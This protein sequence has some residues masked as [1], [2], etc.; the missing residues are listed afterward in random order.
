MKRSKEELELFYRLDEKKYLVSENLE[1]Q[2]WLEKLN[3]S[4]QEDDIQNFIDKLASWYFVK[5]PNKY[6][7]A[8]ISESMMDSYHFNIEMTIESLFQHFNTF[9]LDLFTFEEENKELKELICQYLLQLVGYEMIYS[10]NSI[11]EYGL[12]RIRF[13]F[14]DF[15]HLFHWDLNVENYRYIMERDYSIHNSDNFK[16]LKKLR[17]K[18]KKPKNNQKRK[19][20]SLRI[21][22]QR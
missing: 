18:Q 22:F 4:Y 3:C 21:F 2:N 20:K 7:K 11:P 15:N 12:T 10:K 17:E 14:F 1:L 9:E 6:F 19:K 5:Y 16:L 13:M 8:I